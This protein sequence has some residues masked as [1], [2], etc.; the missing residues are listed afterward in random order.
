MRRLILN[1]HGIGTPGRSL[2]TGEAPYWVS[3][4]LYRDTVA[5]AAKLRDQVDIRFTFDDGNASDLEI[6]AEALSEHGFVGTFFVLS[7]RIDQPGSLSAA[8]LLQLQKMGHQ[9]GSHGADHVDWTALD[10]AGQKREF[11]TARQRLSEITGSTVDQ[12]AIPF[13]RYNRR[14]LQALKQDGFQGIY[15]SDK[16]DWHPRHCPT[17]RTS[18]TG[19][20]T[21]ET[22]TRMLTQPDALKVRLKRR[23]SMAIKKRI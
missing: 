20:M 9:I 5:L 14:V 2:E 4:T 23:L 12:A 18:L 1:L 15:S 6:G 17:P 10:A 8:D 22:I 3:E 13:G 7:S 21:I 11:S 19:D 16:G